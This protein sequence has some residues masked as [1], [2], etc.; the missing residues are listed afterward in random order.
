MT[1]TLGGHLLE[2]THVVLEPIGVGHALAL[3]SAADPSCLTYHPM[4]PSEWSVMG[5]AKYIEAMLAEP[6]RASY[7]VR[8][9][10]DSSVVGTT[11]F[12]DIRQ[13]HLGVE[14]GATW[15]GSLWR[16]T[17]VNPEMKLLLFQLAFDSWGAHRV[18]LKCDG[19]NI[20]SQR[21][22]EKLGAVRE[23][24]LRKHLVLSD[25]FVRDTVMYSVT[26]ADWPAVKN[27]LVERLAAFEDRTGAPTGSA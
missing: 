5:F 24:V 17:A 14:I 19:R 7:L 18:Q 2:G 20:Q 11:S 9:K 15:I 10:Q 25:G 23:G 13:A 1:A 12:L 3:Y 4:R 16:G 6:N 27:G 8:W 22:I 26:A 21:A